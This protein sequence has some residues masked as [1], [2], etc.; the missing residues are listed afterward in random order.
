M[1]YILI[2][3]LLISNLVLAI[4]PQ[5]TRQFN[6]LFQLPLVWSYDIHW[7]YNFVD[8]PSRW[9]KDKSIPI[10][11]IISASN[12]WSDICNVNFIYDGETIV[13]PNTLNN[14]YPDQVNIISWS[15]IP[16]GFNASETIILHNNINIIDADIILYPNFIKDEQKLFNTMLHEWG[17]ILGLGHSKL[18]N[19][20]MSG[21]PFTLITHFSELTL[22]DRDGCL[23]LYGPKIGQIAEYTCSPPRK[24]IP[25]NLGEH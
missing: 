16:S 13:Q 10:Q 18:E 1:K 11:I 4:V 25:K 9:E 2:I 12:K 8:T 24:S 17:H 20:V 7:K 6:P 14:G 21:P 3:L 5:T 19:N 15:K 23:C 22:D